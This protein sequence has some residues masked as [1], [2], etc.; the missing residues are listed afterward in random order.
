MSRP[1]PSW[2]QRWLGRSDSVTI[3]GAGTF[4]RT[5]PGSHVLMWFILGFFVVMIVWAALAEVDTVT[6]A[7]GKV[8][9]SARL[10]VLQSLEGGRSPKSKPNKGSLCSKATCWCCSTPHSLVPTFKRAASR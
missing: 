4:A 1:T 9:P 3:E 5:R 6:R 10:Q 2:W 8:V 7:D